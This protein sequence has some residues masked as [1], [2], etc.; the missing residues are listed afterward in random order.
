MGY[1]V[2]SI[3]CSTA[4]VLLFKRIDQLK[5]NTFNVIIVNYFAALLLGFGL[6]LS[7]PN[8]SSSIQTTWFLPALIIGVAFVAMFYVI[9]LTSQKAGASVAAVSSRMSVV[10]PVLFS[11]IYYGESVNALKTT[12]IV[13]A[14]PA[15]VMASWRGN[16]FSIEKKYVYLPLILFF[17]SGVVDSAVKFTQQAYLD[18]SS[19]MIFSALLFSIAAATGLLLRVLSK[20]HL[21]SVFDSSIIKWGILLGLANWGSLYFFVMALIDSGLDSS[22]VF[23][24]NNCGILVLTTL[25]AIWFFRE[26]RSILNWSGLLLALLVIFLLSRAIF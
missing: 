9:A 15:L 3:F 13:L 2:L 12:G 4:I 1:L 21:N 25:L 19:I 6:S 11:I 5:V 17:G 26:K 20:K 10:V 23:V 14:L 16:N 7:S 18:P 24:I 8:F 22:L